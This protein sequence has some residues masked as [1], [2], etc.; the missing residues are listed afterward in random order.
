MPKKKLIPQMPRPGR[1]PTPEYL[2]S[3]WATDC[4]PDWARPATRQAIAGAEKRLGVVIPK[5]VKGQLAVQNGGQVFLSE[6]GVPFE[7]TC[8]HWMNAI[9]DGMHPVE[10][11][12]IATENHWFQNAS[13][14]P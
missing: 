8:R 11:W 6:A 7:G 1:E 9:V 14:V 2:R 3:V 10:K 12:E 5:I 4:I 13:D